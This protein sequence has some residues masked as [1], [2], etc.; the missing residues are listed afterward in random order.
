VSEDRVVDSGAPR[1]RMSV[2]AEWMRTSVRGSWRDRSVARR[3]RAARVHM[4][5]EDDS[6]GG[7]SSMRVSTPRSLET[8]E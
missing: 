2:V 5:V 8:R 3:V 1:E 6:T 4:G 7:P